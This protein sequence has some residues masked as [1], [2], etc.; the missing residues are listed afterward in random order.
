MYTRDDSPKYNDL[1][2]RAAIRVN[3]NLKPVYARL[4]IRSKKKI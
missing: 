2:R 3:D 4:L 1:N